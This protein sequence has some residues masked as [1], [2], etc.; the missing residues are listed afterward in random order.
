[1]DKSKLLKGIPK[2][3]SDKVI[4]DSIKKRIGECK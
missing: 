3:I 1:M 4:T 2:Q